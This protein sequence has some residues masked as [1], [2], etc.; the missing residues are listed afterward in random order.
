[1]KIVLS[2]KVR[3]NY[4]IIEVKDNG[5]GM[6]KDVLE[7]IGENFYTTKTNG[8]GLGVSLSKEIINLHGGSL[9][10]KSKKNIGTTAIIKLPIKKEE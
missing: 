3:N 1:M 7:K 10:Y 5:I 9:S 4:L 8:T 6:D 2:T